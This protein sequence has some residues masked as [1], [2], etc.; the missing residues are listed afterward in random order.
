MTES[1]LEMRG[2][3]QNQ[4]ASSKETMRSLVSSSS[5]ITTTKAG[6]E[7]IGVNVKVSSGLI[8]K[9]ERRELTDKVLIAIGL[10]FFFGVVLYILQKRLLGWLWW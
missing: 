8:S 10:I 3:L 9:Y 2:V 5:V 1:L 6:M 7:E 4:V